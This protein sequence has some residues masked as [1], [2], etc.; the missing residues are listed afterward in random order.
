MTL[1]ATLLKVRISEPLKAET[2][3]RIQDNVGTLLN[4]VAAVPI[5]QGNAIA[6]VDLTDATTLPIAYVN[7]VA[8]G[9]GRP[10]T[11]WLV[12]DR[13]AAEEVYSIPN[14][15]PERLLTLGASGA[16]TVD[17]LVW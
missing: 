16:V 12:T 9:L 3:G 10:W 4:E 7:T 15:T 6:D 13:D 5:L 17:V 14:S 2:V 1:P 8:H 11:G